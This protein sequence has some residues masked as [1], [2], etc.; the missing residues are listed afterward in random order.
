MFGEE[1]KASAVA[2][3]LDPSTNPLMSP[4]LVDPDAWMRSRNKLDRIVGSLRKIASA[5][6]FVTSNDSTLDSSGMV[7]ARVFEA[8]QLMD[9]P[10]SI[11]LALDW[12]VALQAFRAGTDEVNHSTFGRGAGRKWL[13]DFAAYADAM[14][15]AYSATGEESWLQ[16]GERVLRRAIELFVRNGTGHVATVA[17]SASKVGPLD[18]AMPSIVDDG[19]PPALPW[20]MSVCFRYGS[21]LG[22]MGLRRLATEIAQRYS[23]VANGMPT[24]FTSFFASAQEVVYTGCIVVPKGVSMQR[25]SDILVLPAA[26]SNADVVPGSAAHYTMSGFRRLSLQSG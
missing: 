25:R 6:P 16:D 3:G 1:E 23:S 12:A 5:H 2:L 10:E 11:E 15:M 14:L 8:A 13:G 24:A 9:D 17:G 22:D 7:T 21:V 18:L 26:G 4:Y 20:F 19:P